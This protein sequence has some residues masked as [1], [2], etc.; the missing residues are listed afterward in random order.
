MAEVSHGIGIKIRS[1][2]KEKG[3]TLGEM[4]RLCKCS[5]SLLSQIERGIVN[6]SFTR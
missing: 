4:A 6:P 1:L 3:M 5:S 2:R